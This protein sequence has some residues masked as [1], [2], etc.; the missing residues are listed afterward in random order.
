MSSM[1]NLIWSYDD[2]IAVF[3]FGLQMMATS[4]IET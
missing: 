2:P 4:K 1:D 3:G